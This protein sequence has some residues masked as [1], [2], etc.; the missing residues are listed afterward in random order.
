[1]VEFVG[2][3]VHRPCARGE[4]LEGPL[5]ESPPVIVQDD[6][7]DV[8]SLAA[9]PDVEVADRGKPGGAPVRGLLPHLVFDVFPAGG[10]LIL[11]DHGE[12]AVEEFTGRRLVDVLRGGHE[13]NPEIPQAQRES[14]IF[15]PVPR[16]PAELIDDHNVDV[17]VPFDPGD[18]FAERF[19]AFE[20]LVSRGARLDIFVHHVGVQR[21]GFRPARDALR[22]NRDA[23]RIV[24]G[25]HLRLRRHPKIENRPQSPRRRFGQRHR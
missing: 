18:H 17:P 23:F 19:A 13:N 12:H 7:G 9:D 11:V 21:L 3:A 8:P 14:G 24:V 2:Q 16:K 5:H 25:A 20:V 4:L 22:R 1:M 15:V 6:I 10:R